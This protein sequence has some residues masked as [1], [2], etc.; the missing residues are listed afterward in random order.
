M[1]LPRFY[2]FFHVTQMGRRHEL[3]CGCQDRC[4]TGVQPPWRNGYHGRR[5][6]C[7][8]LCSKCENFESSSFSGVL[9]RCLGINHDNDVQQL[10]K[11]IEQSVFNM[12]WFD[13]L[14]KISIPHGC[15]WEHVRIQSALF[16]QPLKGLGR[17]RVRRQLQSLQS[18]TISLWYLSISVRLQWTKD[19]LRLKTFD[20]SL[21]DPKSS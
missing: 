8:S 2:T 7:C 12:D 6:L 9:A 5:K 17:P 10:S 3:G 19:T 1:R 13:V 16:S 15:P 4:E 20:Y 11:M 14:P 21:R 18:V